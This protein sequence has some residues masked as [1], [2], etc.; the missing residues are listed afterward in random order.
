MD[1]RNILLIILASC[2]VVLAAL[3]VYLL[4]AMRKRS[5]L[6][7]IYMSDVR[8]F[9]FASA[10]LKLYFKDRVIR[11]PYLRKNLGKAPLKADVILVLRGGIVV[12]TVL[13]KPGYYSTPPAKSWSVTTE[14]GTE[15][16]PSALK[17][18]AEL[19]SALST[20]LMKAGIE[21]PYI[22][23]VV[24]LSDDNARVDTMYSDGVF[25]G[26]DIIPFCRKIAKARRIRR[27]VQKE[28]TE[29]IMRNHRLTKVY[30]V[31]NV[32]ENQTSGKGA[33]DAQDPDLADQ[34]DELSDSIPADVSE[35]G[36][37]SPDSE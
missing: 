34:S 28:I 23:N 4:F 3:A 33:E 36:D 14:S 12:I 15:T 22:Y 9:R 24:L 29:V 27:S 17:T 11:A 31:K 2:L 5:Q 8:D 16:I 7:G 30:V 26:K 1:N 20:L 10:L 19:V 18:G 35:S 37:S 21:C 32:Y 13:D 25:T 6:R